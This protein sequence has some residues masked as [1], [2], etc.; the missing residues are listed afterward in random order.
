MRIN[1]I[2][3][4]EEMKTTLSKERKMSYS[5]QPEPIVVIW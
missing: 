3:Q 5:D 4:S 1:R 2:S